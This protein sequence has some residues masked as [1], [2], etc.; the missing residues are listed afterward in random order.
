MYRLKKCVNTEYVCMVNLE[1]DCSVCRSRFLMSGHQ[2]TIT[3]QED[4]HDVVEIT[5]SRNSAVGSLASRS[6]RFPN[7]LGT[8]L[9]V[10]WTTS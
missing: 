2:Y 10:V 9:E 8:K 4:E 1:V 6:A 3:A 7:N 5:G